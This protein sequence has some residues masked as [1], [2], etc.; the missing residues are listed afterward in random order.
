MIGAGGMGEVYRGRDPR[1][2]RDVALKILPEVFASDPDRLARFEREA[3]TLAALSHPHVAGIYGIEESNGLRA[4]ALEFVAGETL[5]DRIGRGAIPI[6]GALHIARE[7]AEALEAAHEQ[8]II[9]RDL[10]P[11][12]IKITPEGVVKVL[13]F[14][15]AKLIDAPEAA[16]PS[17]SPV[18]SPTITSPALMTQAGMLLGTAAYM[19]PEQA[20][21][22]PVDKRA[23]IWALGCV[24]YEM[25]SGR[26]AFGGD[27][28][29]DTI[30]GVIRG[31]ADWAVLP[32]DTPASI[33]RLLRRCL[34][35]DRKR[36]LA[37][38]ADARFEIES[39][40]ADDVGIVAAPRHARRLAVPIGATAVVALLAGALLTWLA[41]RSA[42]QAARVV[43]LQAALP[44][45]TTLSMGPIGSEVAIAP[46]GS[47]ILYVGQAAPT[48]PPQLFVRTLDRGET[49]PIAGTEYA[50]TPFFS[51]DGEMVAFVRESSLLKIGVRGGSAT[52]ICTGCAPGFYGGAWAEDDTI[53]FARS[54]GGGGLLRVRQDGQISQVTQIDRAAGESRHG[55]PSILPDGG[56]LFMIHPTG[57]APPDIAVLDPK[58][59][60]RRV[61]VRGGSQPSYV[62][63]GFLVFATE[64]ALN[65]VRFD[66]PRLATAG[67]PVPVLDRVITKTT[68]GANYAVS[69]NGS[70]VYASG[71]PIRPTDTIAWAGRDGHEE[72]IRVQPHL[73]VMLRVSP[74]GQYVVLDARDGEMDLWLW[75]F[76]SR[77]MEQLTSE[78]VP[79]SYPVWSRNQDRR[80]YLNSG[81]SGER[82]LFRMDL[83]RAPE[84]LTKSS[85]AGP[86][87][88]TISPD[89]K[90]LVGGGPQT[91]GL[92]MVSTESGHEARPLP[93]TAARAA[94]AD[95][96]PD[97]QWIAYETSAAGRSEIYLH[98]FPDTAAFGRKVAQGTRPLWSPVW[99]PAGGELEL[100]YLDADRRLMSLPVATKPTFSTRSPT[101]LLDNVPVITPGRSYDVSPDGKRFLILKD[102][103]GASQSIRQLEVVL[104]W[105]ED[106]RRLT[107]TTK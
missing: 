23:D 92:T 14:G 79:D 51:P 33:R 16:S 2:Q 13:D 42:P 31:E 88:T 106:L 3:R 64:G 19:A 65:A 85:G 17:T 73:Y 76:K 66:L 6:D 89:E 30:A 34:E 60:T 25:L 98:P 105:P 69:R 4:L 12:N 90:W 86:L 62:H 103:P 7:I 93:G 47:R 38:A 46:D 11:A 5:A 36:R 67:T 97:G 74:D 99:S 15:L 102:G 87:P 49:S 82:A 41:T 24:L 63:P 84:R 22:Q 100:F 21:G 32:G 18:V 9:H 72:T 37:D 61:I 96:S 55:Y 28:I 70:L 39:P 94:N 53:V 44:G 81:L 26:R 48:S 58:A 8:G 68:R 104:N 1:L 20:R 80:L 78:P 59:G 40:A 77:T 75:E 43:R 35:K 54:G 91:G 52:P 107:Q 27:N 101:K 57:N 83:P 56:V 95:I 71:D 10:K 45:N 29:T 50:Q